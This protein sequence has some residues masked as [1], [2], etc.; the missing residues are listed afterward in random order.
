MANVKYDATLLDMVTIQE[1][2]QHLRDF[3]EGKTS[4]ISN[5]T[6][7]YDEEESHVN[8]IGV[9]NFKVSVNYPPFYIS[10][11]ILDKISHCFLIDGGSG[12][13]AM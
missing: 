12:P 3:M 8:R 5:L 1:Q 4:N 10:I 9:N 11:N 6:E 2:K 13:S 7:D